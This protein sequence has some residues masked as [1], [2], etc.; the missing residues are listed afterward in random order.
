[1]AL[2]GMLE[3]REVTCIPAYGAEMRGGTANCTVVISSEEIGSPVVCHPRALI[4]LNQPSLDKFGSRVKPGGVILI[5]TSMVDNKELPGLKRIKL[6]GVA[7]TQA[8]EQL[9]QLKT[10]NMVALGAF[11]AHTRLFTLDTAK[12][13]VQQ[14]FSERK[15]QLVKLN[16]QA[17]ERGFKGLQLL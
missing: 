12:A 10:A 7:A 5:N 15:P 1:M 13:A 17:I 2:C 4:A 14:A 11:I 3:G 9:G 16:S 8:A 6:I